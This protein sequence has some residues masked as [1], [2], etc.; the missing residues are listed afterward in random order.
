MACSSER[1]LY[2]AT[3]DNDRDEYFGLYVAQIQKKWF[4]EI[5]TSCE[6]GVELRE[7]EF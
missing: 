7:G 6:R 5:K 3:R 1:W 4:E 2:V